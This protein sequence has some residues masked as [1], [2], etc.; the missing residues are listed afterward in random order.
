[1]LYTQIH[2]ITFVDK[3]VEYFSF[4]FWSINSLMGVIEHEV[5]TIGLNQGGAT[6]L[7][8]L[9]DKVVENVS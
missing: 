7:M 8:Q 9:I 5:T 2:F 1:M 6:F 3:V 4:Y